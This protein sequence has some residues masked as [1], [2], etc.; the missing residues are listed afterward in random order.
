M[1][2]LII[3]FTII[4]VATQ[5]SSCK[6]PDPIAEL[7]KQPEYFTCKIDGQFFTWTDRTWDNSD[8]LYAK[9]EFQ[10]FSIGATDQESNPSPSFRFRFYNLTFPDKDTFLV[11]NGHEENTAALVGWPPTIASFATDIYTAGHIIF[12]K[13]E[14]YLLEGTFQFNLRNFN[15]EFVNI[16]E[17]KFKIIPE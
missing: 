5:M 12:S 3:L 15:G 6:K 10:Q 1:K 2:N 16:T 9:K 17:G 8:G 11:G 7:Y 14:K 4:I 13:R